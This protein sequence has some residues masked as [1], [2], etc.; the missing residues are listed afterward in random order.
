MPLW[1]ICGCSVVALWLLC[2]C[3][4]AARWR[5]HDSSA[6]APRRLYGSFVEAS[7]WLNGASMVA[8]RWLHVASKE[9]SSGLC[10]SFAVTP[11]WFHA[12]PLLTSRLI[13]GDYSVARW[14]LRDGYSKTQQRLRV[15]SRA[16]PRWFCEGSLAPPQRFYFYVRLLNDDNKYEEIQIKR[17][18]VTILVIIFRPKIFP[19]I[20]GFCNSA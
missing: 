11:Q 17:Q 10:C 2:D 5:L 20:S 16:P 6:V 7:Q 19:H 8:S 15:G 13:Q 18:N 9:V 4:S 14:R 1:R 3:S 12:G